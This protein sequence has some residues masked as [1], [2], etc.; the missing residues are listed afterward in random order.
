MPADRVEY[1]QKAYKL[2]EDTLRE[3]SYLVGNNLTLADL[4][5]ISSISSIAEVVP[6]DA[7]T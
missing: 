7:K 2:L 5:V 4:S 3:D 1:V 6:A